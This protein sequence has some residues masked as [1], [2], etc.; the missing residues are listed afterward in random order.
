M[1]Y[2]SGDYVAI[3]TEPVWRARAN[4]VFRVPIGGEGGDSQWEQLWWEKLSETRF[5]L[6]CIP[7][8]AYDLSL[9]DEVEVD[10]ERS[11]RK[12]SKHAGQWTYR[13][14]FGEVAADRRDFA[15]ERIKSKGPTMEWSSENLLALSVAAD[16]AQYIANVLAD[17]ENNGFLHY[18]TGRSTTVY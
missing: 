9:G 17:L 12:V 1:K 3:H 8:F 4:F 2:Q 11:I 5:L 15:V 16:E 7:F 13:V 6:C 18:E 14:W 10:G